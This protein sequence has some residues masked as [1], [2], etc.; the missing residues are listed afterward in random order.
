MKTFIIINDDKNMPVL[1][2]KAQTIGNSN[3]LVLSD[4]DDVL[5][6]FS[7]LGYRYKD[8]KDMLPKDYDLFFIKEFIGIFRKCGKLRIHDK[9]VEDL[10]HKGDL[11]YWKILESSM[12]NFILGSKVLEYIYALV[13]AIGKDRPDLILS[14]AY[15]T[16]GKTAKAIAN[17]HNIKYVSF[18]AFSGKLKNIKRRSLGYS[19]RSLIKLKKITR[20]AARNGELVGKGKR[21]III[22]PFIQ[23][24]ITI[25]KPIIEELKK[26]PINDVRLIKYDFFRDRMKNGMEKA[27]LDYS[28]LDYYSTRISHRKAKENTKSLKRVWERVRKDN[29]FIDCFKYHGISF[30]EVTKEIFEYYFT[31]YSMIN[32][33]TE[34]AENIRNMIELERPN[35]V[36]TLD[37][38]SCLG[39]PA[40][41]ISKSYDVPVLVIQHGAY[42]YSVGPAYMDKIALWGDDMKKRLLKRGFQPNQ[43]VVTG[44]PRNDILFKALKRRGNGKSIDIT[45]DRGVIVFASQPSS[46]NEH[47]LKMLFS[48]FIGMKDKQL[49][50]K[51]HPR[52]TSTSIYKHV[53]KSVGINIIITDENLTSLLKNSDLMITKTS[54][55]ALDAALLG[56]PVIMFDPSGRKNVPFFVEKG[57]AIGV[58]ESQNLLGEINRILTDKKTREELNS[59]MNNFISEFMY[60][61]DGKSSRRIANL[62]NELA[63]KP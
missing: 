28:S 46:A 15:T 53:A 25:V 40:V 52:E 58:Y 10:F 12:A 38:C 43:I 59:S 11:P 37:E 33:I 6:G 36:I 9:R 26:N 34:Y 2:K 14:D 39:M 8:I 32:E 41:L 4:N 50:V 35:I 1:I 3:C 56:K 16:L 22:I 31:S 48:A 62:V 5:K 23:T 24:M 42:I 18:G 47:Y 19:Y 13:N 27:G 21:K 63:T 7:K 29:N 17:T 54:S 55:A 57:I 45:N 61:F 20:K 44:C 51:T 30:W 49:V 60:K